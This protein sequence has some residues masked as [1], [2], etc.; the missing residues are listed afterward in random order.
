MSTPPPPSRRRRCSSSRLAPLHGLPAGLQSPRQPGC[1][2][3][4]LP[5]SNAPQRLG[6]LAGQARGLRRARAPRELGSQA[7]AGPRGG[8]ARLAPPGSGPNAAPEL[9]QS[10]EARLRAAGACHLA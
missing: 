4:P 6:H 1:P 10:S 7:A 3:V 5:P 8:T 2:P 9:A